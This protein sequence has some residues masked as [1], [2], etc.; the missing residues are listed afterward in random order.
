MFFIIIIY[1]KDKVNKISLYLL[2]GIK[3]LRTGS[4]CVAHEEILAP[5]DSVDQALSRVLAARANG[6]RGVIVW[7]RE[8]DTRRVFTAAARARTAGT[9]SGENIFWLVV[10]P[11][12]EAT[13]ILEEFGDVVSGAIVFR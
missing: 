9:L 6:A 13:Q 3:S 12:G 8:E 11:Q 10:S 4:V 1:L 7:T 5:E 2:S